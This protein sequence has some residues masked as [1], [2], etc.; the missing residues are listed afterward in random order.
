MKEIKITSHALV[1]WLQRVRGFSF[2]EDEREIRRLLRGVT[3][4]TLKAHNY[5]FEVVDG[6][7]VTITPDARY[8]N[9]TKVRK[10]TGK[11]CRGD[12]HSLHDVNAVRF[13]GRADP[14]GRAWRQGWP[15]HCITKRC[16]GR[17]GRAV[18]GDYG[19]RM[20]RAGT[21]TDSARRLNLFL[22]GF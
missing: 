7:L 3:N 18:S 20:Q 11:E 19:S 8:P 2:I 12:R 14:P 4:G 16:A 10:I 21:A 15:S 1:R 22:F 6:V 13:L 17:S 9:K 5:L